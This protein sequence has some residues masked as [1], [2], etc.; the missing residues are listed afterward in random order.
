VED[1]FAEGG[2]GEAVR[3]ALAG[4][5]VAIHSLA[6]RKMPKSGQPRELLEYEEISRKAIINKVKEIL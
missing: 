1:H 2:M 3:T 5:P 6:V 4:V